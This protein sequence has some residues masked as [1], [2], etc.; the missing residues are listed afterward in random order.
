LAQELHSSYFVLE[1]N[2]GISKNKEN[3][4]W[5]FASNSGLILQLHVDRR[6]RC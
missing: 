2:L 4:L 5:S 3:S 1:G 6:K